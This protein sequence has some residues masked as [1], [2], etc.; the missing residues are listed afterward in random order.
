MS[1]LENMNSENSFEGNQLESQII[2]VEYPSSMNN[3]KGVS[4]FQ[5]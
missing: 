5:L 3:C 2:G 4:G 1:I